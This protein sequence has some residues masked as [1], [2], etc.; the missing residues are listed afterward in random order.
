MPADAGRT[1]VC[2]ACGAAFA[3]GPGTGKDGVSCWCQAL[4]PL[5]PKAGDDCLCPACLVAA[6]ARQNAGTPT[7]SNG[8]LRP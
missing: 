7:R 8:G 2:S 5:A 1:K 6:V 3:C 4:P